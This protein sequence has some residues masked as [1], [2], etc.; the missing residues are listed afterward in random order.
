MLGAKNVE[1]ARG[2]IVERDGRKYL[3][4]YHPAVRFYREDLAQKI[5]VDFALL[6]KELKRL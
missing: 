2:K 1:Q 5:K 6:M 3:A 4:S